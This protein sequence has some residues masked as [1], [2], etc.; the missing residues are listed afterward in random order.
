MLQLR[1]GGTNWAVPGLLAVGY[2]TFLGL[3]GPW[4][5]VLVYPVKHYVALMAAALANTA[6]YPTA[7]IGGMPWLVMSI[8]ANLVPAAVACAV[9]ASAGFGLALAAW[10]VTQRVARFVGERAF[11]AVCPQRFNATAEY[12]R[13]GREMV[14]QMERR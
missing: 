5:A 4:L 10:V 8:A 3:G 13:R 14:E 1:K 6:V 11:T 2:C 9:H 7:R 12:F